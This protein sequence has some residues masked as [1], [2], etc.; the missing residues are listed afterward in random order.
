M[1]ANPGLFWDLFLSLTL[2]N[3]DNY[4]NDKN[5]KDGWRSNSLSLQSKSDASI[6]H[7]CWYF[8]CVSIHFLMILLYLLYKTKRNWL[9]LHFQKLLNAAHLGKLNHC[10]KVIWLWINPLR[11]KKFGFVALNTPHRVKLI[12]ILIISMFRDK[13]KRC[14]NTEAT[15][16]LS[17]KHKLY[18]P[19]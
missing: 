18:K 11:T 4:E 16:K 9:F 13:Q 14:F 3:Y 19:S 1:S 17:K 12:I 7:K 15:K 10:L 8:K 6:W 2:T 5:N